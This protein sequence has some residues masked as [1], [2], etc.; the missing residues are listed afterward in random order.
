MIE[1]HMDKRTLNMFSFSSSQA[2]KQRRRILASAYSKPAIAHSRVQ[3]LIKARTEKL[4]HFVNEQ[5]SMCRTTLGKSGPIV[6]RNL[7]RALQADIFTAFA[8][9][10]EGGTHFLANLKAGANTVEDLGLSIMDL[11]HDEK[12]EAFFFW[13][14]EKPFKFVRHW[15]DRDGLRAHKALQTWLLELAMKFEAAATTN[16]GRGSQSGNGSA[17]D[18]GV[19]SK[20][21]YWKDTVTGQSLSMQQRVSEIMDHMGKIPHLQYKPVLMPWQLLDKYPR[22]L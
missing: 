16:T 15:F 11:C 12:R 18:R 5:T 3:N 9:S 22:T 7:F 20:L 21:L 14:S 6:I 4:L 13:G 17:L 8:F 19:Y 2:H 1:T 10:E